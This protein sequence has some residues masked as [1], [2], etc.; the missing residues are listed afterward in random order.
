VKRKE[1]YLGFAL[2][3]SRAFK[4]IFKEMLALLSFAGLQYYIL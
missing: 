4:L 2:N 1:S 3:I